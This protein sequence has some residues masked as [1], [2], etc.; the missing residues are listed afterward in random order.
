MIKKIHGVYMVLAE[1]RGKDGKHKKLGT[2]KTMAEAR[3]RLQQVEFF[4]HKKG[5]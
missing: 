4:K 1:S 2:Y 3:K 5:K